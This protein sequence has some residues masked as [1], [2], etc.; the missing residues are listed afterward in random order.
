MTDKTVSLV[1]ST[2]SIGTQA[3]D[4]VL[5]HPE[6]FR[7]VALG[8]QRSVDVLVAQAEQLR[9]DVVAVGD[10]SLASEVAA[11]VPAGTEVLAGPDGLDRTDSRG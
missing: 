6:R 5:A 2:G 10:A 9:P 1:G 8:A 7:V 4:V 3:I 11:R